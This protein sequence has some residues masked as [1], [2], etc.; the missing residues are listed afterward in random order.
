MTAERVGKSDLQDGVFPQTDA[1]PAYAVR[2]HWTSPPSSDVTRLRLK[3]IAAYHSV[4]Q[5]MGIVCLKDLAS[6]PSDS[7][8]TRGDCVVTAP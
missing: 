8:I 4:T 3:H 6:A 7:Q 1:I 2:N 5:K